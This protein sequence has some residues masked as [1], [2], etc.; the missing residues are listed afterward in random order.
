[1]LHKSLVLGRYEVQ[2]NVSHSI[3]L[4]ITH[5]SI[6]LA[7]VCWLQLAEEHLRLQVQRPCLM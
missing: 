7:A 4:V 3:L 2:D 5:G 1:M 6:S